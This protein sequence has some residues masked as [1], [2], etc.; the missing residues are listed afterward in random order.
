MM[1]IGQDNMSVF[2]RLSMLQSFLAVII[3]QATRVYGKDCYNY[4]DEPHT[5]SCDSCCGDDY[6]QY[7]CNTTFQIIGSVIGGCLVIGAVIGVGY[8]CYRNKS[9]RQLVHAPSALGRL[10]M[11]THNTN[12]SQARPT[13]RRP[14]RI[15]VIRPSQ[16]I[17]NYNPAY[18]SSVQMQPPGYYPPTYTNN[19]NTIPLAPTAPMPPPYEMT[20]AP[21]PYT[22]SKSVPPPPEYSSVVSH[23][24]TPGHKPGEYTDTMPSPAD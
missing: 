14:P 16:H 12:P 3:L 20:V 17:T 10:G 23:M 13:N 19:V 4:K 9:K 6:E 15:P 21:P 5:R 11:R 1:T 7:C 24:A 8:F 2:T 22:V 18:V